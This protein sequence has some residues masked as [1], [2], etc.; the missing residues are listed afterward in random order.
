[1]KR[2]ILLFLVVG[3]LAV[4]ATEKPNIIILL[5]DDLGYGDLGCYGQEIIK[6]PNLD[7]LAAKGLRFT[8]F[9]AGCSVCSPSR[10]V[11]MT[12][13]HAGHA[14]I[15]GNKGFIPVDGSWDRIA[16][17]KSE[18]TLAEMLKGAGYQTAFVGKWHLGIPQDVSTWAAGRGFDFAVQ[19]QWGPTPEGGKYDER[20]HWVNGCTE[21]IFHDYTKHDCLDEFRTDIIMDFLK[22]GRDP[23]KP[24]F[25]F[26]SYRS[27]HAHE[28]HLRETERYKEHGWPEIERRHAAR[29]T[30]LDE[31]IQRLLDRLEEMGELDNAFI[32]FASDNGPH[33]EGPK[34]GPKHDP[35]FFKS[36]NGLKGHKR[37]MYE[38]GVRVPGFAYWKGK[39]RQGLTD[40]QATFYD[41]MPTLAEVAGIECPKQ[42]DGIS[43]LSEVLGKNQKKHDHLYWE[44]AESNSA[45]AFRQGVRRG[46]WKAVRYGQQSKVELYNL[47][48]DLYET[49]NV[50]AQHPEIVERMEKI[51]N[52][53]STK[54]VHYPYAGGTD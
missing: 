26:M 43:F 37:D 42:T 39:S 20:D 48:T 54:T 45:K 47:K 5:A 4:Q 19:E 11:L 9:Y 23:E 41:V 10:G 50:A 44:I 40:H 35:L 22:K 36:S 2:F 53:E 6:T 7:A 30:M 38:G 15:R 33:A 32:L 17:K 8:D 1:M 12:G 28:F 27:P 25:L 13:I 52:E 14:T 46:D 34:D 31:Q 29:I 16:L 21:S 3:A 24:L 49:K 51:L 18:V